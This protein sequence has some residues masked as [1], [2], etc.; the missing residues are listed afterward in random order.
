MLIPRVSLTGIADS[1]TI[2]NG[3]VNGLL[4]FNTATT[5]DIEPG[6][7]YW[8]SDKW[9]RV[10]AA[11][12]QDLSNS[13]TYADNNITSVVNEHSAVTQVVNSVASSLNG[14]SLVTTV[15]GL[16][17]NN[18]DL[19]PLLNKVSADNGLSIKD[20]KIELGGTLLKPTVINASANNT[21]SL[22]GLQTGS[23]SYIYD[24]N[25]YS[26][27]SDRIL[28]G[29][30]VSGLLKQVRSAMPKFFYA[31]SVSIPTHNQSGVLLKG[32]QTIDVYNLYTKQFGFQ[33]ASGQARS[34]NA[35]VLPVL[36]S[37]DLD[38]FITYFDTDIFETVS[39]S[40]SGI[41]TYTIKTGAV[42]SEN[43]YMNI[44][45]KVKD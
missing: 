39:I 16:S 5:I 12:K 40:A 11:S 29:D 1:K 34:N 31:P 25:N 6:F 37:A 24:G 36:A 23:S 20:L 9:V 26:L 21:L 43:S 28:V 7:Y 2:T 44:V 32:P 22:S 41:I 45:F 13:L 19:T 14:S 15:N 4:I 18:L 42:I 10:G 30:P 8:Y 17:G 27:V 38:Y 33:Q 3:N 35:S